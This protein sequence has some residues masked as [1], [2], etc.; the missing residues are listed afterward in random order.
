[1]SLAAEQGTTGD[2]EPLGTTEYLVARQT[3]EA[4]PGE[5]GTREATVL[6]L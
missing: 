2:S 6:S 3:G 5:T 4:N 1:V